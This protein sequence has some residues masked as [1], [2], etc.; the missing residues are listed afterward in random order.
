MRKIINLRLG[1]LV[2][3][4]LG[5]G[6]GG[7]LVSF[8]QTPSSSVRMDFDG[9]RK[10]DYA[11]I[12]V[13]PDAPNLD[14]AATH[15]NKSKNSN[16]GGSGSI[17]WWI[18]NSSNSNHSVVQFGDSATD[19]PTPND[20][21]GDGK[22]DVAIWRRI[23]GQESVFFI[24]QSSTNTVRVE[25]FGQEFDDPRVT[26]D[27]DGDG[28]ADLAVYRCPLNSAGTCTFFYRGSAGNGETTFVPW[29][30]GTLGSFRVNPGDFD[31][32]GKNDFC[33]RRENPDN[34]EQGQFVLLRSSDLG[35]EYINWGNAGLAPDRIAPGDYDGDGKNDYAV[36]RF[37]N[38]GQLGWYVLGSDGETIIY[39]G[40]PFGLLG[41]LITQGDY[42]GDGKTDIS[43]WREG[44]DTEGS[45]FYTLQSNDLSVETFQWGVEDDQV[46]SN[47]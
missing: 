12:R 6:F 4:V 44:S 23:A 1:L 37:E 42:D 9:D 3:V 29:G 11:I 30:N 46:I 41:D 18:N 17:F 10:S 27:Y 40:I 39:Y 19:F 8:A 28:K 24:I 36:V 32:D 43:V 5:I 7:V 31:G 20:F 47:F 16:L 22:T 2:L 26:G 25:S 15:N 21:D 35:V 34:P 38:S 14:G 33:I 45:Y 13:I